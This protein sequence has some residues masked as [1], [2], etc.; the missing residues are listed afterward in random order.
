MKWG[1]RLPSESPP[2]ELAAELH[3][4]PAYGTQHT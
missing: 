2:I 3:G 4:A 1:A